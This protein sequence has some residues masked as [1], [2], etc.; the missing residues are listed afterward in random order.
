VAGVAG[1]SGQDFQLEKQGQVRQA[2]V[3]PEG[4]EIAPESAQ[5]R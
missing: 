2:E 4:I 3:F 1:V 5:Q